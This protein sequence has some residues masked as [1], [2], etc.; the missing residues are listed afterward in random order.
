MLWLLLE[1]VDEPFAA[2]PFVVAY[3]ISFV[4]PYEE[5]LKTR[6]QLGLLTVGEPPGAYA[7]RPRSA[8]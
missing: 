6:Q 8:R 7:Q 4:I 3:C 2:R 5:Q 1:V